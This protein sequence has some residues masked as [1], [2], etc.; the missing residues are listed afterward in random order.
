[1][2]T[3]NKPLHLSP[4]DHPDIY[5]GPAPSYSFI[6]MNGT[7]YR[8]M[9]T[10]NPAH[11]TVEINDRKVTLSQFLKEQKA[12]PLAERYPILSYGSNVCLAQLKYKYSLNPKLDDIV[13]NLK[14]KLRDT[15]VLYSA[16]ITKY[17]ALPAM[18]GPMKG[19]RC[20]VWLSLLDEQQLRH[21][22]STESVYSIAAHHAQKLKL[23]CGIKPSE[24]YAYYFDKALHM[25]GLHFRYPD[26]P[27]SGSRAREMWQAH[28][29]ELMA[30]QFRMPRE[31]FIEMVRK[32][33]DFRR[34][35]QKSLEDMADSVKHAD[36]STIKKM[37]KWKE[38]YS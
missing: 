30:C 32:N 25:G 3:F 7:A 16:Y 13:I 38:I 5:P 31:P 9:G 2:Y 19:A 14:G 8:L 11:L 34:T 29:L 21:I 18:L 27:C 6:Y 35:V 15:D 12:I 10:G 26:I 24:F 22:N 23:E 17:G 37:R 28:M 33:A 20:Q 1:M 4:Y 36:W